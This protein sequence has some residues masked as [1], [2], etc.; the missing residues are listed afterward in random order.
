MYAYQYP[1]VYRQELLPRPTAALLTGVPAFLGFVSPDLPQPRLN[2]PQIIRLLPEFE[3]YFGTPLPNRYLA[4]AVGGFFQNGGSLC[5]VVPLD[6]SLPLETALTRGL[7]AV[8]ALTD[9]DLI[10]VPD[11]IRLYPQKDL[12]PLDDFQFW[13][14]YVERRLDREQQ[15]PNPQEV[16]SLQA[17]ILDY[18]DRLGD[19]FA[20]LD[21]LPDA[22][23]SL[24]D[25]NRSEVLAQRKH[26][27]SSNGALYY[28]WLQ[29]AGTTA[30]SPS[31]LPPSG[32]VAG[33]YARSDRLAGP[34]KAP[35]N[36][37]LEGVLD[38]E[39][40]LTDAQ[41]AAFNP[42]GINC[43]RVFPGRGIRIWG[44]RTLSREPAWTYVNTRRLFLTAGRWLERNLA[45]ATFEPHDAN[46]WGRI[47]RDLNV[48][49]NGLFRQ[50]ALKGNTV[51]E[52]F[53][54]KCDGETNPPE[55][56]ERG[57]VVTEIGLAPAIPSEFIVVYIIHGASGIT[58]TEPTQL[59]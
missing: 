20:I 30:L 36:E 50:G 13:K 21:S 47:E 52:A 10:C 28:P 2:V 42:Q 27:N 29:V 16:L 9:V 59:G 40:K 53:Y 58:I 48:Y 44:A 38:L 49:F 22:N 57:E 18:C 24:P 34:H 23:H 11:A 14:A 7:A 54:V 26:L 56:R 12:P 45:G 8:A 39:Q 15:S 41:Q 19:R 3:Q 51:R 31:W 43:L 55:V 32:H 6:G 5:Y 35:A 37:V 4:G 33:V 46:L 1:G 25:A 17:A